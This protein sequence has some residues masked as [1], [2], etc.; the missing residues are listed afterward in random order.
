MGLPPVIHFNRSFSTTAY[1][2]T[3]LS[4]AE[5]QEFASKRTFH[6]ALHEIAETFDAFG[7]DRLGILRL[8]VRTLERA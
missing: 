6:V 8:Q 2:S 5:L 3:L 1:Y 4:C 7:G